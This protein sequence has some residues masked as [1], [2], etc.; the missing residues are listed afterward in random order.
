M[1]SGDRARNRIAARRAGDTVAASL[2]RR[3]MTFLFVV[4]AAV[5]LLPGCETMEPGGAPKQMA[6]AR[7][8]KRVVQAAPKYPVEQIEQAVGVPASYS[9]LRGDTNMTWAIYMYVNRFAPTGKWASGWADHD[10]EGMLVWVL[11]TGRADV[12]GVRWTKERRP[13]VFSGNLGI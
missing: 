12:I 7:L 11:D 10:T 6:P 1:E 4:M 8:T 2:M 3:L 9:S 5:M 13:I